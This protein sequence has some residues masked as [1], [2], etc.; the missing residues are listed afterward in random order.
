[1]RFPAAH[2]AFKDVCDAECFGDLDDVLL[3][4]SK[5]GGRSARDYLQSLNFGEQVQYLLGQPVA[6]VFV[7]LVAAHV[8]E[9]Q[10]GDGGPA[11]GGRAL[12]LERGHR[13]GR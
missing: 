9:R 12:R 13:A 2:A 7:F 3:L 5:R 1:M 8:G 6:E 11:L 4:A 10:H